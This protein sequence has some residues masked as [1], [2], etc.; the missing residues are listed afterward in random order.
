MIIS[1]TPYRISFFGG[2]TDYPAW[3]RQ[4]GGRVL[5]VTINKYC[6]LTC[7]YLPPFFQ[8]KYRIVWS[9]IDQGSH[10]EEITHPSAREVIKYSGIKQGLEIHHDGDLPAR[11]GMGSSSSF[12]V[13]LLNALYGLQGKLASKKEL[14]ME[15]IDIEQNLIGEV[16]GSQDQVAAAYGGFNKIEFHQNNEIKVLPVP[17]ETKRLRSLE[18]CLMLFFTGLQ[19]TAAGIANSYVVDINSRKKQLDALDYLVDNGLDVL[20]GEKDLRCFGEL[21]HEG[22]R[23]K[24]SLSEVVSNDQIDAIYQRARNAGAIGGKIAGAGAGGFLLLFVPPQHQLKVREAL[25]ELICV[26]FNFDFSGSQI[27]YLD[28]QERYLEEEVYFSSGKLAPFQDI[29]T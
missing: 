8:H 10:I 20:C 24:K 28:H 14:A 11:S 6:Y 5:S 12:T 7:R 16:V 15:S 18:S 29:S 26:P 23:V 22:W 3:Y 2:G 25:D 27:I 17:I 19:R 13:G 9:R 21:L 4:Y 1:R